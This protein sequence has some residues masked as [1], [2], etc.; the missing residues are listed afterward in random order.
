MKAT[1]LS[2]NALL[3]LEPAAM[4]PVGLYR[5]SWR[6]LPPPLQFIATKKEPG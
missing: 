1:A 6:R 2:A 5:F 4:K 3:Y